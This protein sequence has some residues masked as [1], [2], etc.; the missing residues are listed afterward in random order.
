ML[1]CRSKKI[2]K[3]G[4]EKIWR[5]LSQFRRHLSTSLFVL[6]RSF[7]RS[8]CKVGEV[9]ST[10]AIL[11]QGT[12]RAEAISLAFFSIKKND[13]Q[14]SRESDGQKIANPAQ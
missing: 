6:V 13:G 7:D 8:Y 4:R 2:A 1:T 12:D 9:Q 5:F 10:V 3:N 11:A 14:K